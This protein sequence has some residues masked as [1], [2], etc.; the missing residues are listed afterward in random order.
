MAVAILLERSAGLSLS[1]REGILDHAVLARR[2][3]HTAYADIGTADINAF[4]DDF[5]ACPIGGSKRN[6]I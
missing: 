6:A 2:R 4:R 5:C 3:T 1:K